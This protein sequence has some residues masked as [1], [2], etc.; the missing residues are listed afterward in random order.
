MYGIHNESITKNL[1]RIQQNYCDSDVSDVD[2]SAASSSDDDN[3]SDSM[4]R[5]LTDVQQRTV[6]YALSLDAAQIHNLSPQQQNGTH[7]IRSRCGTSINI[8]GNHDSDALITAIL[9]TN[10]S[11]KRGKVP[12]IH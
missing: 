12:L 4:P 1:E 8:D 7:S 10:N 5:G 11:R 6:S 9:N 3:E 2:L